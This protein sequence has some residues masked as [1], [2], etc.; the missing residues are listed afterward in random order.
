MKQLIEYTCLIAMIAVLAGCNGY[1]P[2]MT[3]SSLPAPTLSAPDDSSTGLSLSPHLAWTNVSGAASYDMQISTASSFASTVFAD[4]SIMGDSAIISIAVSNLSPNT[5]YYWRARVRDSNGKRS[6]WSSTWH[7]STYIDA[8]VLKFPQYS[9]I[10]QP[11]AITLAW[12]A[13]AGTSPITYRLQ[14]SKTRIF[15]RI[16]VDDSTLTLC[17]KTIDSLPKSTTLYW[18]VNA[19]SSAGT[20]QWSN[21]WYFSTVTALPQ[22]PVLVSPADGATASSVFVWNHADGALTYELQVSADRSFADIVI[23]YSGLTDTSQTISTLNFDTRY[24][25][26]LASQNGVGVSAWSGVRSFTTPHP[27]TITDADGNVYHTVTIGTQTWMV[28]NLKTTKYNDGTAIPQITDATAWAY[29]TTPGY[30]WYN[31]SITE[32][33]QLYGALYNWYAVHTGKLA[34]SGWHVPT[35]NDWQ[36][37]ET[38]L[39]VNGYNF[40]STTVDNKIAKSMAAQTQWSVSGFAGAP[41]NHL[42]T[43][44]A[45]GFSAMPGG[46]RNLEGDFYELDEYGH[47]WSTTGSD[48]Q[49]AYYRNLYYNSSNFFR[50]DVGKTCGFSVRLVKDN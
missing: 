45:S 49:L 15:D 42:S 43:N 25:W 22:T 9:A 20:S 27:L 41:G 17:S 6:V 4:S 23:D 38:Y 30:C 35:E 10:D 44:N 11:T 50:Y 1:V 16:V 31:N 32:N 13:V 14:I 37:L 39:I 36:I 47:W 18:R 8:P 5:T 40:D 24:Y 2:V 33:K 28:E 48:P 3:Y 12:N 19:V 34:P 21:V 29:C 46:C 7:F 26:R